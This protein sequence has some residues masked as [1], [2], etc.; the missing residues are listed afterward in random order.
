MKNFKKLEK[1]M[2]VQARKAN[3]DCCNAFNNMVTFYRFYDG[4]YQTNN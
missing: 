1:L 2:A 4:K 3:P